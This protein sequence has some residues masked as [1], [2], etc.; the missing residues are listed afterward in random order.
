M[1]GLKRRCHF[2]AVGLEKRKRK[3][4]DGNQEKRK[5]ARTWNETVKRILCVVSLDLDL[6][7]Y[8][9][10]WDTRT[11]TQASTSNSKES[12]ERMDP[13][14]FDEWTLRRIYEWESPRRR[15]C[16]ERKSAGS[17]SHTRNDCKP[18]KNV[19]LRIEIIVRLYLGR[20]KGIPLL[21][22][23]I[24]RNVWQTDIHN[25]VYV[26]IIYDD[27]YWWNKTWP[28]IDSID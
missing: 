24:S 23:Q 10:L 26:Y 2:P 21:V 15:R 3:K 13:R 9:W 25:I 22:I 14:T 28:Q 6:D 7:L 12:K 19:F 16:N 1:K 8:C 5:R 17:I 4:K 11:R 27:L 20:V 18:Y